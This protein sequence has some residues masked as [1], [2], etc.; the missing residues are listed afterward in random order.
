[1]TNSLDKLIQ[2]FNEEARQQ[3]KLLDEKE[4]LQE[5]E[6]QVLFRKEVPKTHKA[7]ARP[8]EEGSNVSDSQPKE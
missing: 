6:Y 8:S 2:D 5:G 4:L 1:M 7:P 3:G